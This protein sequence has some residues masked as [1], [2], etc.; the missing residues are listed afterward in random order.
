MVVS[1]YVP[2]IRMEMDDE[3]FEEEERERARNNAPEELPLL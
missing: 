2:R 1:D 3:L